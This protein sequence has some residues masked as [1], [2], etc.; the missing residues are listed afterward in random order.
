MGAITNKLNARWVII[1]IAIFLTGCASQ[2]FC[3]TITIPQVVVDIRDDCQ[4]Y[5]GLAWRYTSRI[6]IVGI[7]EEDGI[8][9]DNEELGHEFKHI[10]HWRDK[11]IKP[12]HPP[13]SK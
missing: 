9:I 7:V 3:H 6:C 11:A 5:Q 12:P 4:G 1:I 13:R 2:Q 8:Y 10:L